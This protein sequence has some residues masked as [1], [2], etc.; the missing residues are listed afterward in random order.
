MSSTNRPR[1]VR[2]LASSMR[3]RERPRSGPLS[4][5]STMPASIIPRRCSPVSAGASQKGNRVPPAQCERRQK[6]SIPN[7]S[8]FAAAS[9]LR[10]QAFMRCPFWCTLALGQ[11][12]LL[13]RFGRIRTGETGLNTAVRSMLS[14]GQLS[15]ISVSE[16]SLSPKPSFRKRPASDVATDPVQC[17]GWVRSTGPVTFVKV[18]Q[19]ADSRRDHAQADPITPSPS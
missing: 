9:N 11:P 3:R 12:E 17:P 16:A 2:S 5:S 7:L 15:M 6:I 13:A 18:P 14:E 4:S 1:P 10:S 8:H 19:R